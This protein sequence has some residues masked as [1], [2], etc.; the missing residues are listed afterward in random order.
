M[1]VGLNN[2]GPVRHAELDTDGLALLVGPNAAG[3][4]TLSATCYAAVLAFNKTS[5]LQRRR[6]MDLVYGDA[7]VSDLHPD[8]IQNQFLQSL[9]DTFSDELRRCVTDRL[10]D[11]PRRGRSGNGAAPRI[12]IGSTDASGREWT[13][14]FRIEGDRLTI[15]RD[16]S[17]HRAPT[18][19]RLAEALNSGRIMRPNNMLQA[20]RGQMPRRATYLPAARSGFMQM[21]QTLA[22]LL[23]GALGAG[24]F[25]QL[26]VN[27]L[28]GTAVDFLQ[29]LARLD[30][31]SESDLGSDL[32]EALEKDLLNGR[33]LL[34]ALESSRVTEFVPAGIDERWSMRSVATSVA[35]L[36][37]LVLYLRYQ[38]SSSDLLFLDEPEAHLHPRNQVLLARTLLDLST[39]TSGLVVGTHSEFFATGVSNA[40]LERAKTKPET[41][42]RVRVYE[43]VDAPSNCAARGYDVK[44]VRFDPREGF[45]IT[46]FTSVADEAMDYADELYAELHR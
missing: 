29:L 13:A 6:Y 41:P 26:S 32:A 25:D 33:V 20:F 10:S 9:R 3:K 7:G 43:L 24:Y 37:P 28:A 5:L 18:F 36:A 34:S 27:K 46:Q 42:S 23:L 19:T 21:Q 15:E 45:E 30:P 4:T 39:R 8:L 44:E 1:R 31:S 11:L 16:H 12:S 40:I 2:I 38:L 22:A 17:R 14:V 35:E